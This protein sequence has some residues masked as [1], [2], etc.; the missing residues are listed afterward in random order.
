[1]LR[2]AQRTRHVRLIFPVV[3]GNV[4]DAREVHSSLSSVIEHA[5]VPFGTHTLPYLIAQS[6]KKVS[7]AC[8]IYVHIWA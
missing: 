8:F 5:L 3:V 4:R 6:K 1:M 2:P 7:H